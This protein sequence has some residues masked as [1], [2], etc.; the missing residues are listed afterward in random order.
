M[1]EGSVAAGS[2]AAGEGGAG[3][4]ALGERKLTTIHAIGQSLAIG[5]I[6]SGAVLA[7][8]VASVAGYNTPLSVLLGALGALALAYVISVYARRY[9]GAGAIYEYLT[10]GGSPD[11]GVFAAGLYALGLLF[12]GGG[13]VFIAIGFLAEGFFAA[14]LDAIAIDWWI[15]GLI[16]L[17]I[18]V[19]FN[20][21]GVRLAIWGVL[22]LAIVSAIPLIFLAISIIVQGGTDGN[23][24]SPF[25]PGQ[26]DWTSVFN[27]ILFAVTLFIGFEA[28]ASIGE[29]TANPR[30]SIPRAV[31]GTVAISAAFYLLLTYAATIGFGNGAGQEGWGS[32]SPMGDLATEYV[33]S[34]LATVI[35]LVILLDAISLSL[36]FVV[37]AS[38]IIFAL[39][40]DGLLPRGLASVSGHDTPLG[41]NAVILA[42]GIAALLYA[43][44]ADYGEA[45]EITAFGIT[46][47]AG[48]YLIEAIYVLLALFAFKLV[49]GATGD[50]GGRWWKIPTLLAALA[51]PLLAYYG[52]FKDFPPY[53][54]NRGVYFALAAVIL[55]AI[56]YAF[57]KLRHPDRIARAGS[58]AEAHHDVPP[59]DE[60]LDYRPGRGTPVLGPSR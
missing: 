41:G 30:R 59:L 10:R 4:G 27:G 12:L 51:T 48:S 6:F 7:A 47:A 1:S 58:Y 20:H 55:V 39:G 2:R 9:S 43:G 18:A 31:L 46:A 32:P 11:I 24:L 21:F 56:W 23:T 5:P 52:S 57:L 45:T 28:A 36:A 35:D 29:E 14:H 49:L 8:L 38:R 25:D 53:P 19:G 37:A 34:G 3:A 44:L 54:A 17:A 15:W 26:T 50:R 33:G 22:T 60:T 40:R 13:G 16:G 42:A